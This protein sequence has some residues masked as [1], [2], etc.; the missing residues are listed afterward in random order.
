MDESFSMSQSNA[1]VRGKDIADSIGMDKLY[2]DDSI[3]PVA[4]KPSS[5]YQQLPPSGSSLINTTQSSHSRA[6]GRGLPPTGQMNFQPTMPRNQVNRVSPPIQ[7]NTIQ[8]SPVQSRVQ[9]SSQASAQQLGQCPGSGSQASSP[10]KAVPSINSFEPGELDSPPESSKSKTA[11]VGKGK[12]SVQGSGRG[13]FL[14]GGAQ[15]VGASGNMGGGHGDQNF[16]PTPAFLPVMQFGGQHPGGMGVPA[17]GMAFPGYVAQPNGLGNSEM[18]WLPDRH[19]SLGASSKENNSNKPS[20]EW[21]P[22]QRSEL[23][24]DEFGQRQN[25]PRRYSK[26]NFGQPSSRSFVISR[27]VLEHFG[28]QYIAC[29]FRLL[30]SSLFEFAVSCD[31][32]FFVKLVRI[33][34]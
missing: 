22:T 27:I 26:M 8:R 15:V 3:S 14:Y 31:L 23:A 20:N 34:G 30:F 1:M 10:P 29:Y 32:V 25:N 7:L 33:V 4:G 28:L 24:S 11:L 17:L 5:S 12:G 16:P 19:P 21:K 9:P 2:I 18:T 6:Q 13:S